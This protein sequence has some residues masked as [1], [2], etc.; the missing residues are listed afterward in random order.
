MCCVVPSVSSL[1]F[2]MSEGRSD[3]D[4]VHILNLDFSLDKFC[5]LS[6]GYK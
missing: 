3:H 4:D 5:Y 1:V 6:F 2:G